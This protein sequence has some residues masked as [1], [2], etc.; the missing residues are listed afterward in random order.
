MLNV[1]RSIFE[2]LKSLRQIIV[3]QLESIILRE[4]KKSPIIY[5]LWGLK[6]PSRIEIRFKFYFY[7]ESGIMSNRIFTMPTSSFLM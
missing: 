7:L 4:L 3:V 2:V 5:K 1:N 6:L